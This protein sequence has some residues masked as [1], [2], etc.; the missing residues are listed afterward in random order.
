MIFEE[1]R[2][3]DYAKLPKKAYTHVNHQRQLSMRSSHMRV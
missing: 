1:G 2:K 3:H